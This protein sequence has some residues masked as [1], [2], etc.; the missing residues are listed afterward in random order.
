[1]KT[2]KVPFYSLDKI[3]QQCGVALEKAFKDSLSQ[4]WFVLGEKLKTFEKEF[5]E[6]LGC[7]FVS[8]VANGL[9]ALQISLMAL[10]VG[11]GDEVLV[12]AHTFSASFIAVIQTGAKPI[13]VDVD[14]FTCNLSVDKCKPLINS[15]TKAIM[16]VHLY[17]NPCEMDALLSLANSHNLWVIE[18]NAQ[19]VG[20]NYNG[21]KTG[22][23][24]H[25]NACSFYPSKTIGALGDAGVIIT[26]DIK[27][28]EKVE[29]LR[30]YGTKLKYECDE[31]GLNSRMDEL[32]AAFLS[33]KLP[34]LDSWNKERNKI[35]ANY[36]QAFVDIDEIQIP[37][38]TQNSNS[39][40][41][42]YTILTSEREQ[43]QA[44]LNESGIQTGIHYPKP[45]YLQKA[46]QYLGYQQGD[47][48]VTE[49]IST[50]TLSLPIYPG[51]SSEDQQYVIDKVKAFF[52]E[53]GK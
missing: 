13:P 10:G 15:R 26:D 35:A 39:V 49:K 47:F 52:Q 6:Y 46:F 7:E 9:E 2:C 51:L 48:P 34:Y 16:P 8:G 4:N 1:M 38:I 17:G 25:I 20:A 19:A 41:H 24:G 37:T 32:Q 3:H 44:F 29:R 45:P 43:L 18:D 22:S 30:N 14:A 53:K 36:N 40:Y 21:K 5:S 11:I 27:L 42:L 31:V 50:T 28:F 12:P 23:F 33:V